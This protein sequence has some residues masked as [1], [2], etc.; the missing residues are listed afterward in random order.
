MQQHAEPSTR[1]AVDIGI[2]V[3][4]PTQA[5]FAAGLRTRVRSTAAHGTFATGM[6]RPLAHAARTAGNFATGTRTHATIPATGDFATGTRALDRGQTRP[7]DAHRSG[8]HRKHE[9]TRWAAA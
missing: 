1:P 9:H 2:T 7:G 4:P 5:D 8:S 3:A 6:S